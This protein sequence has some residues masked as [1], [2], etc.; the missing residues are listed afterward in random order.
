MCDIF[1]RF[2]LIQN[3]FIVTLGMRNTSELNR[4]VNPSIC[5]AFVSMKLEFLKINYFNKKT[6]VTRFCHIF[7][8]LI[9]YKRS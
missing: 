5:Y 4:E 1:G 9:E 6:R 8:A 2:F 3:N 7:H